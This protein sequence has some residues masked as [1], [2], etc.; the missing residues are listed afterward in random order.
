VVLADQPGDGPS[1]ADPRGHVDHLA[2]IVQ[3]RAER[4]AL[5]RAMMI[6]VAFILDQN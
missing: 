5:M 6:E 1:T 3:R 2:L 4:T